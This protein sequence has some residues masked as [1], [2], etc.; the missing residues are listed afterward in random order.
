[1]RLPVILVLVSAA[2][3]GVLPPPEVTAGDGGWSIIDGEVA[4]K[5]EFPWQAQ[6]KRNTVYVCGAVLVSDLWLLTAA[7]CL[8]AE[9]NP[10]AYQVILGEYDVTVEEGSEQ[11]RGVAQIVLPSDQFN[12]HRSSLQYDVNDIALLKIDQPAIY[13][14]WVK[15][16][17]LPDPAED[18]DGQM[19][20]AVGWGASGSTGVGPVYP[21]VLQKITMTLLADDVCLRDLVF[22][23]YVP[24]T[25]SCAMPPNGSSLCWGDSGGALTYY[26][27]ADQPL[28]A[29]VTSWG[30]DCDLTRMPTVFVEVSAFVKWIADVIS[31]DVV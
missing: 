5:G 12:T 30:V 29:A 13:T 6:L 19:A 31:A 23:N 28:L 27:S 10:S 3:C 16:L 17:A 20:V 8:S 26:K 9:P 24:A 1:M 15:A 18:F 22:F 4:K 7:H 14:Q 21:K 11:R 25:M 2:L